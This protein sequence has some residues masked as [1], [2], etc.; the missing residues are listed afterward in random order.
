MTSAG[1]LQTLL[2]F[3]SQDAKIP[4]STAMAKVKELQNASLT[5]QVIAKDSLEDIFLDEKLAKQIVRAAKRNTKKRAPGDY[6]T[7]SPSKKAKKFGSLIE[8]PLM[9]AEL[10]EF[11]ALPAASVVEN[12]ISSTVLHTNRAP[13][14]LAFAVVLLKYT[15]PEQPLS[16]R[17]SL[18]QA[19]VSVNS[20]SRAVNIGL[21]SGKSAEDEGW[22]Q[23][24][25]IVKI[26]G[27]EIR[28]LRRW[29]YEWQ[30]EV[31][32]PEAAQEVVK[33]EEAAEPNTHPPH[34]GDVPLWGLD[35]EA[36]KKSNGPSAPDTQ[37]SSVGSLPIYTARS[38]RAYL[39]KSFD[40]SSSSKA[41]S[42]TQKKTTNATKIAEKKQALG[43]LLGA[44][45]LLYRSWADVLDK[46]ELDR[47]AWSWYV[48]VRPDV[49]DGVAGWG[50]KGDVKLAEILGLRRSPARSLLAS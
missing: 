1:E 45:E 16:S 19:V 49:A 15:M 46:A 33:H 29:G 31:V 11:L 2:R 35:L 4:L 37:V 13:L 42:A 9:P 38:A 39:L 34:E 36:L 27:R 20:R 26:M 7:E 3:L 25:P 47:R 8:E 43:M 17:L 28:V 32:K 18:A 22:G 44:L 6:V 23:G 30:S 21:E 24:Q 12:E 40:C 10:E 5:T 41:E 48:R 50:G 14:V